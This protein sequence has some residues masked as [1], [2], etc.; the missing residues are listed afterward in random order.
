MNVEFD[1]IINLVIKKNNISH[2]K[3]LC[4]LLLLAMNFCHK[5]TKPPMLSKVNTA[6][7]LHQSLRQLK[8]V[9]QFE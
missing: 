7:L 1:L 9:I 5:I 4:E 8:C 3:P 6:W 2:I